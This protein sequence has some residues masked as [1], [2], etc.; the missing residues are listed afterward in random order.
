MKILKVKSLNI[1]SLKG[2]FEID[3]KTFLNDNA[4]FAITGP[5]GA[6]KSTILDNITCALYGRTPRLK[7]PNELM[8]RHTGESLCEVE[9]EIKGD[10]YRSSWTQKRARKSSDGKF[11]TAKMELSDVSTSKV[12]KSTLRDVPKYVEELSGL[13]F[14]RFIQSMMLAQGSFDAFLKAKESDRSTLLEKITGTQIYAKISKEIYDTYATSKSEIDYD[15]KSLDD[16]ELLDT[17]EVEQMSK[18]LD[19][20]KKEKLELDKKEK[21]LLEIK[22]WIEILTKLESED[23]KH[24]E[25]FNNINKEKEDKKEEFQK[26]EL[27]NRALNVQTLYTQVNSLD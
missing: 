15:K 2:E 14:D 18:A 9:F 27:A 25:L 8:A 23:I 26:L 21:E 11:Q 19:E 17:K 16:T 6:G 3:F 10:V 4:L 5:T 7:N 13:D 1:N 20:N 24:T 12:I 22:S